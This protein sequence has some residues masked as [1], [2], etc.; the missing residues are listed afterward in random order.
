MRTG[1]VTPEAVAR[2]REARAAGERITDVARE[3]GVSIGYAYKIAWGHAPA[4]QRPCATPGCRG[5]VFTAARCKTCRRLWQRTTHHGTCIMCSAPAAPL[6]RRCPRHL[7][8]ARVKARQ[9]R[10]ARREST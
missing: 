1:R 5:V 8:D 4:Q 2:I 9:R 10:A 7:E 3:H 6:R